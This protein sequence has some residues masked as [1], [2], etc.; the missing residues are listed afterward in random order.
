LRDRAARS[1]IL[2]LDEN[3]SGR[4]IIEGLIK[5]N[6]PVKPQTDLM[7]RGLPDEEVLRILARHPAC[8][9]LT[10]DSDFHKKPAVKTALIDHRIGAFVITS[11]KGRTAA[12][13]V[14]LITRAW[15]RMQRFAQNHDRPFVVKVLA[16]GR[17][18]EVR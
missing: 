10:K 16:D 5:C 3:L 7:E 6:I 11:H 18:E 17:I 14:E 12:E 8:F 9:L 15:G 1:L 13:L 4:R 2:L